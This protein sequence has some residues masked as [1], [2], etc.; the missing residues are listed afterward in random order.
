MQLWQWQRCWGLDNF[1]QHLCHDAYLAG[2]VQREFTSGRNFKKVICLLIP[3]IIASNRSS[4]VQQDAWASFPNKSSYPLLHPFIQYRRRHLAGAYS[5]AISTAK[6]T[7]GAML[8]KLD[9]QP[10]MLMSFALRHRR[11]AIHQLWHQQ[12]PALHSAGMFYMVQRAL[13]WSCG[14]SFAMRS[15]WYF[16]APPGKS[17][18]QIQWMNYGAREVVMRPRQPASTV[19]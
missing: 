10:Q 12:R 8:H 1:R 13:S 11:S 17:V 7:V 15:K 16:E 9:P 5:I 3:F 19:A 6:S 14:W 2:T 4:L 18:T